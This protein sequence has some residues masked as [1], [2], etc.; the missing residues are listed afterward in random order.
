MTATLEQDQID[1]LELGVYLP[2]GVGALAG[3][4]GHQIGQWAR[5]GLITPTAYEGRPRNLYSYYDVAEAIVIHWLLDEQHSLDEIRFALQDVREEW[6]RWPL[7]HAP[8]GIGRTTLD[9]RGALVRRDGDRYLD[10]SGRAPGQYVVQPQML[11]TARDMLAHGG[12]LANS[13]NLERIE[14]TPLKLG[15][16]PSLRGRRWTI[17]HVARLAADHEGRR[18]LE[19][20]YGLESQ[21]VD[22]ALSWTEAAEALA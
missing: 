15:G 16:Q 7:L 22:E 2:H 21:E 3:V 14:V 12:W 8:L 9:D 11:D 13:L 1:F 19:D 10:V 6:P 5:H 20:Q 17:D 4:S 18:V